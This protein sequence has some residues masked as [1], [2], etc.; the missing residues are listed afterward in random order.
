MIKTEALTT[1]NV[2]SIVGA[3]T[4]NYDGQKSI[5]PV[6]K[7]GMSNTIVS[8]GGG[9]YD[10]G[11]RVIGGWNGYEVDGDL[12]FTVGWGDGFAVRRLNNDGTMT[13]LFHDSN[14]L[15]RD[16]GSTY[17]HMQ[18][19]AI[20]KIN[21]KGVVM[22][23]NVYGYTTFDYSGLING[24]TTFVKDPRPSHSNP[25]FFIGS[26]D[27]GNG[28]VRR[29][30]SSYQGGLCAAGEWIYA[31][32]HDASHYKKVMRRN[33]HTGVEERLDMNSIKYPGSA[34]IDR[35][36]YRGWIFYDEINDRIYYCTFYN[37]NFTL[38]LNA[39]TAN[40]QTV[41]CDM[42][43]AGMGDDGYEQ[44]LFVPDP[45]NEPNLIYIGANSRIAYIDI[46]PCFSGTKP[47]VLKQFYTE[48]GERGAA[49]GVQFRAGVKYQSLNADARDRHPGDSYFCPT[50]S[51]RGRNMLDGW[52]DFENERIVGLE[53]HD[54]V[55]EDT[56]TNGRGRSYRSDYGTNVFRMYS[57]N[58]TPY[59]IK[60]GYGYDGHGFRIWE[61]SVGNGL[62]GNWSIEYGTFTLDNSANVDFVNI[63]IDEHHVPSG[64]SLSYYVSNDNGTTWENYTSTNETDHHVFSSTGGQLRV[65]FVAMGLETKA[66][67]KMSQTFDMVTYGTLYESIK[68]VT[69]PYKVTRKKIRG[70][71]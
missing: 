49:F 41:W 21:K 71:K 4:N 40:P 52:I 7:R 39:S 53:R 47:T 5:V 46:T 25:Q 13:K 16:T 67:Y 62:I 31:H 27:T 48:N 65:K 43:D 11:D 6:W 70:K 42:G 61:D 69:I 30:G 50:T 35:N 58:G 20:D 26:Q 57:A 29:V 33:L 68:D 32:E 51:D 3:A 54:T 28:Y 34:D 63:Q 44:G 64:C 17:N 37:A 10:G 24:G 45:V 19:V 12:L 38:V 55:V 1:S 8:T 66:P 2:I 36:G 22:T 14:F 9:E 60:L 56:T 15:W 59:W 23:Y 18:S